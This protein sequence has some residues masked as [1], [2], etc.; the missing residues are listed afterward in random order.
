MDMVLTAEDTSIQEKTKDLC[1]SI[2]DHPSYQSLRKHIDE[3]MSN[4]GA[5]QAYQALV[6]LQPDH[7][8]AVGN[9][10]HLYETQRR[11]G[12]ALP[13]LLTMADR[14]PHDRGTR[15]PL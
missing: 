11:P 15:A 2:V 5:K 12:A 3:F 10:T 9:L 13:L 8:W 1:Q 4:D 6:Q 7:P 14:R